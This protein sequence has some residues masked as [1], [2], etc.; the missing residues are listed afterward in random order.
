MQQT[1]EL[2]RLL[3]EVFFG[4]PRQS[5]PLGR[6]GYFAGLLH[7]RSFEIPFAACSARW[8]TPLSGARS[9]PER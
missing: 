2:L 5:R 6:V 9:A 3:L 7:I 8:G 4:R 1:P